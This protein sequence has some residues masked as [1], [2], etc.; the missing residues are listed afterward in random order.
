MWSKPKSKATESAP[1]ESATMDKG[2]RGV[3]RREDWRDLRNIF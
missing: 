1:P 3:G 2:P